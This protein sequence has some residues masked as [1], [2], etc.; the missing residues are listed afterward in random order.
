MTEKLR[1]I[2]LKG[3][4]P[5]ARPPQP[6]PDVLWI[7]IDRLVV[8]ETYQRPIEKS[9]R[10]N[11]QAIAFEFSWSRFTPVLLAPV[12]EG[13]L[14]IID[15]QHRTHAAALCRH[16]QVPAMVVE[17]SAAERARSFSWVNGHVTA[18]SGFHILKAA[19]AAGEEWAINCK[20]VVE[21][22]DCRLMTVNYSANQKRA[23]Q[24]F[25]ISLIKGYVVAG[26]STIVRR[27]LKSIR[28]SECGD[29]LEYYSAL[30]LRA[31]FEAIEA[32]GIRS[33]PLLVE[34]LNQSSFEDI[35]R[36]VDRLRETPEYFRKSRGVLFQASLG[37]LLGQFLRDR[38]GDP[39]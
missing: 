33:V 3:L 12:E 32:K 19:L 4:D 6:Q 5:V 14:A 25:C 31:W 1:A 36:K 27:G 38:H 7:D 28:Q 9:G 2:N 29:Q 22:S 24:I 39:Q 23:G 15:G 34:F 16:K 10:K 20:S 11:I 37:A 13:K 17:M 30:V 21:Q 8:D 35:L 26:R 18:V